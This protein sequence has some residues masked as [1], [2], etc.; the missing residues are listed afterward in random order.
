VGN[1]LKQLLER[2]TSLS[3]EVQEVHDRHCQRETRPTFSELS[4]L[5]RLEARRISS[6]FIVVDALDECSGGEDSAAGILRE[7]ESI[8]T[9][10]LMITGRPHVANI[11]SRF[12]A[13][14]RLEI[15]AADED[16]GKYLET[17]INKSIFLSECVQNDE[18]LRSSIPNAI[19]KHAQGM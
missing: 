12:G 8:S 13:F 16:I 7:L 5:L 2:N 6:F 15:R 1:L 9:S 19:V 3:K 10:R 18:A 17:E 11:M 14:T 4:G